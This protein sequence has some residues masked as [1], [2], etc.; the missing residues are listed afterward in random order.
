MASA[1]PAATRRLAFALFLVFQGVYLLLASGRARTIDEHSIHFTTESLWRDGTMAVPQMVAAKMFYGRVGR[2]GQPYSPYGPGQPVLAVPYYAVLGGLLESASRPSLAFLAR[3]AATQLPSSTAAAACVAIL[4]CL[5]RLTGASVRAS[6]A[7]ATILGAATLLATYA[8][9]AFTEPLLAL[10]ATAALWAL[11]RGL[12]TGHVRGFAAASALAGYAFLT[13]FTAGAFLILALFAGYVAERRRAARTGELAAL[14]LPFLLAAFGYLALNLVRFGNPLE[15]G[16]PAAVEGGKEVLTFSTPLLVGLY[17]LL[18][19]PGKGLFLFAPPVLAALFG[20]R[21]LL[22]ARPGLAWAALVHGGVTLLFYARYTHWEGGY[23]FGPRYLVPSLPGLILPLACVLDL[24]GRRA[25][26]LVAPLVLAG[27]GVT[28]IGTSTSFLE[29]QAG[30][31][32]PYYDARF[33]YRLDYSLAGQVGLFRKYAGRALAGEVFPERLGL[34]LDFWFVFLG[35]AGLP[36]GVLL[37]W[38]GVGALLLALGA[39][40]ARSVVSPSG[41]P[42]GGIP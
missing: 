10:L 6:V 13:K 32:S 22:R 40:R 21:A 29:E 8:K 37:A 39:V 15:F 7:A 5:S 38:G 42:G 31:P 19:S 1:S 30:N 14:L 34:G 18:L 20:F 27:L 33:E 17:G 36:R 12:E 41:P 16:Y 2:D 23:C 26:K 4:F 25:A 11:A 24:G 28:V 9:L 35:K 3:E